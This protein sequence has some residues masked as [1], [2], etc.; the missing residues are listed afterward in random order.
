MFVAMLR[1]LMGLRRKRFQCLLFF[2]FVNL[3]F[4]IVVAICDIVHVI[5]LLAISGKVF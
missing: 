2:V 1:K 5:K 4:C 3:L